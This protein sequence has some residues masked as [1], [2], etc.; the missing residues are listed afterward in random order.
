M[1]SIWHLLWIVPISAAMGMFLTALLVA[2]G[3]DRND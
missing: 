3:R 2:N 1:I